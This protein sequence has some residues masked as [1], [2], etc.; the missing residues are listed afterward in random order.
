MI[1]FITSAPLTLNPFPPKGAREVIAPQS[2][3]DPLGEGCPKDRKGA[4]SNNLDFCKWLIHKEII[5]KR[6][7][8]NLLLLFVFFCGSADAEWFRGNTHTHTNLSDGDSSPETVVQWYKDHGYNFVVI[9]DHNIDADVSKLNAAFSTKGDLFL[10][11]PGNE[12][13]CKSEGK[14]V[15]LTALQVVKPLQPFNEATITGTIRKNIDEIQSA[16]AVAV[17][18]HPN[19]QWAFGA[20]ELDAAGNVKLMEVWNSHPIVNNAGGGGKPGTE[21]IWDALLSKGKH[22]WGVASDDTHALKD[23]S[24]HHANPGR[25]WVMV[26]CDRL[27][28]EDIMSALERGDFY[29]WTGVELEKI[30]FDGKT[31]RVHVKRSEQ[32]LYTVEFIGKGGSVLS[33]VGSWGALYHIKGNEGYVRARITDSKGFRAWTQPFF[34]K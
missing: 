27:A 10:V 8:V 22:I 14:P 5:M 12:I 20:K 30:E 16:G 19:F 34:T 2:I 7:V 23:F 18:A 28:P 6:A 26:K 21:E 17:V 33:R 13:S 15:H 24:P 3:P 1:S 29:F 25:G 31:F 4:A 11:I 32:A 9:T